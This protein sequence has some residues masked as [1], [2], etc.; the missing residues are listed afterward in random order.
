MPSQSSRISSRRSRPQQQAWPSSRPVRQRSDVAQRLG[1]HVLRYAASNFL[2]NE[3]RSRGESPQERRHGQQSEDSG[4]G[5]VV[6]DILVGQ[7]L[8]EVIQY[9]VRHNFFLRR[10][11]AS[12]TSA[13]RDLDQQVDCLHSQSSYEQRRRHRRQR[14]TDAMMVSLDRL[15]TELETTNNALLRVIN[16]PRNGSITENGPLL[17]DAGDLRRAINRCV[18]RIESVR[19][20]YRRTSGQGSS[21][22]GDG[23]FLS[24]SSSQL[25]SQSSY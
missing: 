24:R 23:R 25:R 9:L 19:H 13:T 6:M 1:R 12:R 7:L 14:R 3:S 21:A 2:E 18:A 10:R 4:R 16:N 20:H 5:Q 22:R 11:T 17:A 8:E 15:S